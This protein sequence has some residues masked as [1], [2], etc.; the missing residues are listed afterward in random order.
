[1]GNE[2]NRVVFRGKP[3][4]KGVV[5][6]GSSKSV[7]ESVIF[8]F[9]RYQSCCRTAAVCM[10]VCRYVDAIGATADCKSN[11]SSAPGV[12]CRTLQSVL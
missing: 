9:R 8:P 6:V 11:R 1:M 2:S 3:F 7:A 5:G 12:R 10:Q 4:A